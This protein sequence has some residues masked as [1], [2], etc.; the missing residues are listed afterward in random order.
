MYIC[1]TLLYRKFS[2]FL[3]LGQMV[4]GERKP[5]KELQMVVARM[6]ITCQN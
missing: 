4:A 6:Y 1:P 5:G 2:S 3:I